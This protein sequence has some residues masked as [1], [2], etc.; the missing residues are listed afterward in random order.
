M[1][2]YAMYHGEYDERHDSYRWVRLTEAARQ[3]VRR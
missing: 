1:N 3:Q 2:W